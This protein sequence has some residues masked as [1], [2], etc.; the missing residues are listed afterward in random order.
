MKLLLLFI[1]SFYYVFIYGIPSQRTRCAVECYSSCVF[2]GTKQALS[3]NC[4]LQ[5]LSQSNCT[6]VDEEMLQTEMES[7]DGV[8]VWSQYI[9]A[10]SIQLKIQSY[11][12]A[13][14]YLFEYA[15]TN[16]SIKDEDKEWIFAGASSTPSI[17]FSMTD[18][19]KEYQFRVIII[20]KT[21]DPTKFLKVLSPIVIPQQLPS[22]ET[23][24]NKISIQSPTVSEDGKTVT[25]SFSWGLPNGYMS[26]DIFGYENP[27]AYSMNC[28]SNPSALLN[29]EEFEKP[30]VEVIK[31]GGGIMLWTL[32]VEFFKEECRIWM[33]VKMIPRCSK[34]EAVD[35]ST[36][37]DLDCDSF[38]KLDLCKNNNKKS[39]C[40][41]V[42][43]VWGTGNKT[44]VHWQKPLQMGD[45]EKFYHIIFG[46]AKQYGAFPYT[47]WRI[48][49]RQESVVNSSTSHLQIDVDPNIP[50]AVQICTI[51][52]TSSSKTGN[53]KIGF[54]IPFICSYCEMMDKEDNGYKYHCLECQKI[55]KRM[56]TFNV[57]CP[58]VN[59]CDAPVKKGNEV[60][61]SFIN[62]REE[63]LKNFKRITN[64][65]D[66]RTINDNKKVQ[67]E[68][69][70]TKNGAG[71]ITD[72]S[73]FTKTSSPNVIEKQFDTKTVTNISPIPISNHNNTI[74]EDV[75][76]KENIQ[77]VEVKA[78]IEDNQ[79]IMPT[80]SFKKLKTTTTP[81]N[82]NVHSHDE[83]ILEKKIRVISSKETTTSTTTSK[84]TTTYT[85]TITKPIGTYISTTIE[86]PT[87]TPSNVIS[88]I[89]INKN[90]LFQGPCRMRNGI[91][92]EYGCRSEASCS[93]PSYLNTSCIR[94]LLCPSII[95]TIAYY[96]KTTSTINII[97]EKFFEFFNKNDKKGLT[98]QFSKLYVEISE[99]GQ[100][101]KGKRQHKDVD[102]NDAIKHMI[103]N[104][105]GIKFPVNNET[106]FE[107]SKDTIYSINICLY[108][109]TLMAGGPS[110][111]Y[112]KLTPLAFATIKEYMDKYQVNEIE[113]FNEDVYDIM[114]KKKQSN[115]LEDKKN[116]VSWFIYLS[117]FLMVLASIIIVSVIIYF[118]CIKRYQRFGNVAFYNSVHNPLH[119]T[120]QL[121]AYRPTIEH[122][123]DYLNGTLDINNAIP[124]IKYPSSF[125]ENIYSE[126]GNINIPRINQTNSYINTSYDRDSQ[127]VSLSD[128]TTSKVNE[129][130]I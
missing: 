61:N 13:F 98:E 32:P 124:R 100:G 58:S 46:K 37:I 82:E 31:S 66:T 99:R 36:S 5:V 70:I 119:S 30:R 85:T 72:L 125:N 89:H 43:D 57:L 76:I 67:K 101:F 88:Q 71:T 79:N 106:P 111:Y 4:T 39:Q 81:S 114:I 18:L 107:V 123:N 40:I 41:D 129:R 95:D 122:S 105:T 51:K 126:N 9:S 35:I 91:V 1:L 2:S 68:F 19:C 34:I 15:S 63:E 115:I 77:T 78:I 94:G 75:G 108:N 3:C 16:S 109:D 26:Y 80:I 14:I 44:N 33:E 121:S 48:E 23:P 64:S 104:T 130:R 74:K 90:N 120:L 117:P 59:Y 127:E 86:G 84:T 11:P 25:A 83:D 55:E 73:Y 6:S 53:E 97:N 28:F 22:L 60:M 7:S 29:E 20:L 128:D 42:V 92:C 17:A 118:C 50:Y 47:I 113:I 21:T 93:C 52:D 102:L 110:I 12:S 54:V 8:S 116:K 103:L 10:H 24:P 65:G 27:Q 69:T 38:P 87:T 96:N 62:N 45:D 56:P 49:D 112:N